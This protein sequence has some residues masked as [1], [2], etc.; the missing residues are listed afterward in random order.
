MET[1][2]FPEDTSIGKK[3]RHRIAGPQFK[4]FLRPENG[5]IDCSDEDGEIIYHKSGLN[6]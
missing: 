3:I 5:I 1:Q 2:Q 6:L 4:G